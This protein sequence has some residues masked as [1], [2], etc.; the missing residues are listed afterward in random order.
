MMVKLCIFP[1]RNSSLIYTRQINIYVIFKF[2]FQMVFADFPIHIKFYY[3]ILSIKPLGAYS[4]QALLRGRG[5]F[6]KGACL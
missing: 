2:M 5:A 1:M 4:F 3:R 6:R